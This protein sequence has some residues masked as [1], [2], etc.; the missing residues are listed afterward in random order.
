MEITRTYGIAST[1]Y[2]PLL[3][4]G[5]TDNFEAT[6]VSFA[7]GDTQ[8]SI[9]GGTFANTGSNP[10]HEGNG[11]YSLALTAAE[12]SGK[13]VVITIRDATATKL[14]SD[15][16]IIIH[17]GLGNLSAAGSSILV[18]EVDTATLTPSTTVFEAFLISPSTTEPPTADTLNGRLLT[19]TSTTAL[20]GEQG[21]ISDYVIANSKM[22]ITLSSALTAAPA[23][24][25][26]FV[27]T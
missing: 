2:F 16:A 5:N 24:A 19:F 27:I 15:Q 22:K 7:T 12:L 23:D 20:T 18:G 10:S 21:S 1:I 4:Y 6:P 25:A 13:T 17:T 9:D 26:T 11:I 14:W 8:Y 3:D